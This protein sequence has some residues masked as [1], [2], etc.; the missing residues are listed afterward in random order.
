M[1]TKPMRIVMGM[2]ILLYCSG[3]GATGAQ[4]PALAIVPLKVNA[5]I[6]AGAGVT[7]LDTE[8]VEAAVAKL[9]KP[10]NRTSARDLGKSLRVDYVLLGSITKLGTHFSLDITAVNITEEK[11]PDYFFGQAADINEVIPEINVI[12]GK[13]N[14][15][16]FSAQPERPVSPPP[17]IVTPPRE[18]ASVYAHP[19][20]LLDKKEEAKSM[21]MPT[22]AVLPPTPPA[23]DNRPVSPF[24]F[25]QQAGKKQD[26]WKSQNL[27]I[28]ARGLAIADL[29]GD[30]KNE[31]VIISSDALDVRRMES[32]RFYKVAEYRATPGAQFLTVDAVDTDGDGRAEIFVTCLKTTSERLGSFVLSL[33]DNKLNIISK[34]QN[35]Y[36]RSLG[37]DQIIG[38]K[39]GLSDIFMPGIWRLEKNG[40]D[41]V[42]QEKINI[43]EPFSVFSFCFGDADNDGSP[44]LL[45]TDDNDKLR[46]YDNNRELLWKGEENVGGSETILTGSK[47]T[48]DDVIGNQVYLPQRLIVTDMNADGQN[49]VLTINNKALGG[50]MFQRFRKYRQASFVCLAWDGLGLSELWHT[51]PVSG[52]ASDFALADIDNDGKDELVALIVSSRKVIISKPKSA[53]IFYDMEISQE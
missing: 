12:A 50:R 43:P 39:R 9:G 29:D 51:N 46:L 25:A 30:K 11:S 32:G 44:D 2:L 41:Y 42:E 22:G 8:A 33:S 10:I 5:E 48:K 17:A 20:A 15:G 40:P 38:Q 53:L 4:T 36:F 23:A 14:Q 27:P 37:N 34:D 16:L 35:W 19:E 31:A 28:E 21:P 24:V 45:L 7:V 6:A 26:F 52:Y 1:L 18:S 49:E 3:T 47:E 13:I